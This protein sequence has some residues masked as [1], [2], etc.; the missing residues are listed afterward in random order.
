MT[1]RISWDPCGSPSPKGL[2]R[3]HGGPQKKCKQLLLR[4]TVGTGRETRSP[5]ALV[6]P[7]TLENQNLLRTCFPDYTVSR[8]QSHPKLQQLGSRADLRSRNSSSTS[9]SPALPTKC[10]ELIAPLLKHG[11]D[12][13]KSNINWH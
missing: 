12:T 2:A 1:C 7:R 8:N 5:L 11:H 4:P 13:N 10:H 6:S 3:S 9:K